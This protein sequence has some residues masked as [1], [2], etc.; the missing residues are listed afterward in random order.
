MTWYMLAAILSGSLLLVASHSLAW[1]FGYRKGAVISETAIL[2]KLAKK[3]G[4]PVENSSGPKEIV[5]P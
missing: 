1:V 4:V 2:R 5:E 3:Y